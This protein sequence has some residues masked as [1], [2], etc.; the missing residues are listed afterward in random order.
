MVKT[1][2]SESGC[3]GWG[4]VVHVTVLVVQTGVSSCTSL[5]SLWCA[6]WGVVVHGTV[7]AVIV[8]AGVSSCKSFCCRRIH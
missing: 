8:Q 2:N 3:A 4:V 5:C 6:G 1:G 7:L